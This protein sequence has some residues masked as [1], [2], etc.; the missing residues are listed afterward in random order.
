[1]FLCAARRL[2]SHATETQMRL[3]YNVIHVAAEGNPSYD[4]QYAILHTI[5]LLLLCSAL[6]GQLQQ[7]HTHIGK[8]SSGVARGAPAKFARRMAHS[9]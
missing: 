3:A 9:T 7:T 5:E 8:L 2:L 4:V 1:M 6:D